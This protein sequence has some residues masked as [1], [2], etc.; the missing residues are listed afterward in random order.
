MIVDQMM[1]EIYLVKEKLS[2]QF[3]SVHDLAE[4]A[5]KLTKSAPLPLPGPSR[6]MIDGFPRGQSVADDDEILR[7]L[8]E[9]KEK[10]SL[11]SLNQHP[12]KPSKSKRGSKPRFRTAKSELKHRD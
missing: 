5:R 1:S 6:K 12:H 2:E 11:E 4:A 8:R 3:R 10:L 7:D 9:V